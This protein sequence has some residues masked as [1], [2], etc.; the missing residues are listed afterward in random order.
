M[1]TTELQPKLDDFTETETTDPEHEKD[2]ESVLAVLLERQKIGY[3]RGVDNDGRKVGISFDMGSYGGI[4]S[5]AMVR[6]LQVAGLLDCVDGF[7]GL[8]SGG[9]N[10][11]FA[12]TGQVKEG[13]DTYL[14]L[15]PD[16]GLIKPGQLFPPR[17]PQMDLD[18]LRNAITK[19]HPLDLEKLVVKGAPAVV[20]GAT[21][22]DDPYHRNKVYKTS[23]LD[24][25]H[26]EEF[27]D[28]LVLGC[29]YPILAG[30]PLKA[31][32]GNKTT[33]AGMAW[34]SA[35]EIAASDG[36]THILSLANLPP[37]KKSSERR[38]PAKILNSLISK[39]GQ[40]YIDTQG[41]KR[42]SIYSFRERISNPVG[43]FLEDFYLTLSGDGTDYS[44]HDYK[45]IVKSRDEAPYIFSEEFYKYHGAQVERIYP[46]DL[47]GLPGLMT[48][49]K[50]QLRLGIK[51]GRLSIRESLKTAQK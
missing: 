21:D 2:H 37:L 17:L 35:M 3:Q 43:V 46:P 32:N 33:D 25:E 28:Q 8:S 13:M 18:V 38:V 49:E 16:N 29:N 51:A 39:A 26:P 42:P 6:K 50:K 48:P 36:C 5:L 22:I 30:G 31:K 10:A 14:N 15:M 45:R 20:I 4:I 11:A 23:E 41:T 7:Y 24:P 47:E 9:V 44:H 27:I 34:E 1:T 12:A 19:D 40:H